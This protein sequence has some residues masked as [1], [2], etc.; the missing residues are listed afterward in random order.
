MWQQ[1]A[2]NFMLAPRKFLENPRPSSFQSGIGV[3]SGW[4]CEADEVAIE[5]D[6]QAWPDGL[7]DRAGGHGCRVWRQQ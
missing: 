3:I 4:V 2:Q 5:I 6:G 1:G 7:W